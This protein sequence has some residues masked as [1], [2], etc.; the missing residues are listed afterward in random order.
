VPLSEAI[1]AVVALE[2]TGRPKGKLVIAPIQSG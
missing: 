1:A 2:R